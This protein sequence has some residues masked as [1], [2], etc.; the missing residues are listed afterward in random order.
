MKII[1][2]ILSF[3]ILRSK[4]YPLSVAK[5][6][7]GVKLDEANQFYPSLLSAISVVPFCIREAHRPCRHVPPSPQTKGIPTKYGGVLQ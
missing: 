1:Q 6:V 3:F 5:S 4:R 7:L 2:G